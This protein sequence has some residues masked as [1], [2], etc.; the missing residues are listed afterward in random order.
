MKF[1]TRENNV[2]DHLHTLVHT[3]KVHIYRSRGVL[4][5]NIRSG[6]VPRRGAKLSRDAA[7]ILSRS[8]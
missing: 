5:R 3:R 7:E 8:D 1:D 6:M 4:E 2:M